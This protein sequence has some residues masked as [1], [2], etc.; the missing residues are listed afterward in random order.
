MKTIKQSITTLHELA[1][2]GGL[3]IDTLRILS[4]DPEIY[5]VEADIDQQTVQV[6]DDSGR[7]LSFRGQRAACRAFEGL[8]IG[9]ACLVHQS[10]YDEMIGLDT[11]AG[12]NRMEIPIALPGN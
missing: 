6:T 8:S 10:A 4:F 9:Y 12:Q 1:R 11:D 7:L 5:L 3:H 2:D